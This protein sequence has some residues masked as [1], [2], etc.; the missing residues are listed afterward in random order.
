MRRVLSWLLRSKV[1]TNKEYKDLLE[2]VAGLRKDVAA[3]RKAYEDGHQLLTQ[4]LNSDVTNRTAQ[5]D[6]AQKKF[7][8]ALE[9]LRSEYGS[10]YLTWTATRSVEESL[11]KA[12]VELESRVGQQ[13]R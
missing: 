5:L 4:A 7:E 13:A 1:L 8:V 2:T 11:R 12:T 3:W 6:D 10:L 9:A